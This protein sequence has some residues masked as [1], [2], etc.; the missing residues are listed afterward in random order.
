MFSKSNTYADDYRNGNF[1][2]KNT[3]DNHES[4]GEGEVEDKFQFWVA[5]DVG[6]GSKCPWETTV[7]EASVM[8]SSEREYSLQW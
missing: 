3:Y 2:K 1:K 6:L 7:A 4:A 5:F 8:E